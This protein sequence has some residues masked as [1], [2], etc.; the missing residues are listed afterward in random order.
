MERA[1]KRHKAAQSPTPQQCEA[2]Q[3]TDLLRRHDEFVIAGHIG[4]DEDT[5]GSC[6]ALAMALGKLGKKAVVLLESHAA[7][8][9]IIPGWEYLYCG[10]MPLPRDIFIALDCADIERLGSAKASFEKARTTVCID[11]HETNAGFADYNFI[12]PAASS[13]SEMVFRVIEALTE[14]DSD[15]ATAVYAGIV[16]DTG[17]FK[18]SYTSRSA[19]EIAAGLMET[20]IPF[21]EIYS[22]VMHRHSFAGAK[23]FGLALGVC[24]T[25]MDGRIVY[26]YVTRE[27]L[28]GVGA[29]SSELDSVVEYLMNTRGAEVALFLYERHQSGK[30]AAEATPAGDAISCESIENAPMCDEISCESTENAP[31]YDEISCEGTANPSANNHVSDAAG[32]PL[33]QCN[34]SAQAVQPPA[35]KK[36]KVSMRSRE[37]HVGQIAASLGGGGHKMAAGCTMVGSMEDVLRQVLDILE[38]ELSDCSSVASVPL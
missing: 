30:D 20:G 7:K 25:V 35:Q 27:M 13:T 19:M 18:H 33:E 10:T 28:A 37:L 15:I 38:R 5:V 17:G 29:D 9:R 36:I 1:V 21:T 34:D 23:A 24:E 32:E 4:P 3:I 16:A 11:H 22:E 2:E 31:V 12:D 26:A 6:F 14:V 8:H